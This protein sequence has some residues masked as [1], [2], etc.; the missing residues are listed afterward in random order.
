VSLLLLLSSQSG[1]EPSLLGFVG[2]MI[3]LLIFGVV[4]FFLFRWQVRLFNDLRDS[5]HRIANAIES[6][7]QRR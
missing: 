6:I 1:E 2:A 4:F 5:L 3:P 7:A